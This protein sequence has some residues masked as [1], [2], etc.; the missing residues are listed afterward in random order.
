MP[1]VTPVC[2]GSESIGPSIFLDKLRFTD[3]EDAAV[4]T[5]SGGN[6]LL[7]AGRVYM[8]SA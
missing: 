2:R 6:T 7:C 4:P 3:R 1:V 8:V 5:V